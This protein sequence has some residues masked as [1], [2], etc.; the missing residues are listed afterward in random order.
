MLVIKLFTKLRLAKINKQAICLLVCVLLAN[1]TLFNTKVY[2]QSN[3]G[4]GELKAVKKE[5]AK[6]KNT[7]KAV[8]KKRQA[9]TAQLKKDDLAIGKVAKAINRTDALLKVTDKKLSQLA[10]QKRKFQLQK[11][12]QELILAEQL[13]AAYTAGEHDYVKML[14]NQENTAEVQ[15]NIS[16]YQYLNKARMKEIDSFQ[17]TLDKLLKVAAEY[18]RQ[19]ERLNTLKIKQ[20][21]Q[22]ANLQKNKQSR[23][24]TLKALRKELLTSQQQLAKLEQEETNLKDAISRAA[25]AAARKNRPA[26]LDGLAKLKNKL[27]WPVKGKMRHKFGTK[28]QG[29]LRWKGVLIQ[30]PVGKQVKAIHGGTVLFSDWLK[31]YGLVTVV[32]HGKGYMSLYGH[33]QALL[34]NVGDTVAPGEAIALVGQSGGQAQTG[35]YF[36]IR[37][38]GKAINPAAWCR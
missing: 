5:I 13:R 12:K 26:K 35:L 22:K 4:S 33:S 20:K 10:K 34:K 17:A 9:L 23:K 30:A 8:S 14:L 21:Q 7:I 3:S 2:A 19:A 18:E 25:A 27:S 24:Q 29:Y 37:Y 1:A 36:E 16:Y 38:K 6:Q 32:D 11:R 31:G 15:R 28:K